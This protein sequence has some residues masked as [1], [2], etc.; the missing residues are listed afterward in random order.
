VVGE[1]G[2]P[3]IAT[4]KRMVRSSLKLYN[5]MRTVRC[6]QVAVLVWGSL[7]TC[8]VYCLRVRQCEGFV[9]LFL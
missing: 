2:S 3:R 6:E 8:V 9:S 1:S 5:S 7:V 4:A